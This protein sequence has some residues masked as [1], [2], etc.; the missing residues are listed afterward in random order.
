MQKRILQQLIIIPILLW[1]LFSNAQTK[2]ISGKVVSA[3]DGQAVAGA[4]VSVKGQSGSA[5][6]KADGTFTISAN[7]ATTLVVKSLNFDTKEVAVAAGSASVTISLTESSNKLNEVVVT[8]LGIKREKK[9]LTYASQQVS[10]DE[11]RVAASPNFMEALSGKAAGINIATSASGAGG[12]TKAVLRGAKSLL[13]TSEALYV[14]D[15]V[16]MV[17]NKG[18]QPGS[19]GGTDQGDGLSSINP[20]DIESVNVLKGA[21][22][23]IL[24]GS[25]GANGVILITT[26]KGKSGKVAVNFNSSTVFDQVSGLPDFQYNYGTP[27]GSGDYSWSK[28]PGSYQKNYIKDF[29]QTGVNATNGVSVSGGSDKTTAYFSYANST[30]T[31]AMPTNTYD[32][33]VVTLNQST[34]FLDD[35]MTLSSSVIFTSE[36]SYNRPGAGYYNNPLTGLYLFARER[37]YAGYKA[38]YSTFNAARN[39]DQMSWYSTEEKQNNPFWELNKDSKLQTKNRVIANVKLQYDIAKHLKF[40]TRANMDY[41]DVLNDNRY[42]AGG[43]SVSVSPNGTWSYS[44]YNDKSVYADGILSY[45]NTFGNFTLNAL[46]GASYT[47]NTFGDGMSVGNG[48]V[49]LQYPNFFSFSNMPYNVMFNSTYSRTIKEGLFANASIGWK[50]MV[51]LDVSARN[52]YAST[53][54]L[55]GN[56][57]YL[58]PAF[59]ASAIISQMMTLPEVISF[60][61]VRASHSQTGNEVPYNVVNPYNSIGGAGGP[62]GIGGINR[63]TQV[64]FTTLKP[65]IIT[66]DEAGF[67]MRFLKGRIGLDFTYYNDES[68]NQFLSL[69]A[70]SGSGYTSYYVNAGKIVNKGYEITVDADIIKTD[71][72]KWKSSINLAHN[73][74]QIVELIASQPNY[75]IGGDDE[76]FSS[77]ILAGGS[78]NDVYVYD[79]ARDA[80]GRIIL[81]AAGVPTKAA[82]QTK[83]GNVN[84]DMIAGWNNSVT[85]GNWFA[86]ALING[87]F[88]GVAF[89]K[90][91]AFLDSYGV[92]QRTA[93]ARAASTMPINAVSSTGTAVTSIDPVIYYGAVGDR[94]KIMSPYIYSRTNVR[95]GQL[96]LGYNFKMK[97]GIIKNAAV[98][99]VGRN[100]FFLSKVAPFDPEQAMSTGNG[101]QSNDVFAM[102]ATRSFGFNV[103]LTF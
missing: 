96:S 61:K 30:V 7:G 81:S 102:P 37:D 15:G 38:N 60:F 52:D 10:G 75:T 97:D 93:D 2:T 13:G 5:I 49:S 79:F 24:Y 56:Q 8:A 35:K 16:P 86:S 54:A 62:S 101:M 53:L 57:S 46:A 27:S 58:Y 77:R 51:Y 66:G 74:N 18:G 67:E 42:A 92:S 83:Y 28:V 23:S 85:F 89:S 11:L 87:K 31:G 103:K 82:T 65:E 4:S 55:T 40:E 70:P 19:Y 59:G 12:S 20:D 17:N 47:K 48:T 64:P 41:N 44:R 36:K 100:L 33:N 95:L 39:M 34:K 91:E 71:K 73:E 50:D 90:T 26:K 14:I 6:S 32:K 98:S 63:N 88:G 29:F 68:T 69:A 43:N 21:N 78:F 22:A 25:Q 80:S 99:F 72:L 94:N 9:A 45:N 3:N 84:P 1:G 76:G